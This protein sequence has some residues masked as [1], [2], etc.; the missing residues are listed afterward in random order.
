MSRCGG[1]VYCQFL[2]FQSMEKIKRWT[3]LSRLARRAT[4]RKVSPLQFTAFV[5]R[6]ETYGSGRYVQNSW[7]SCG[8]EKRCERV[9]IIWYAVGFR[10]E[11]RQVLRAA[12][13]R[14][15]RRRI[16]N[17][18][19]LCLEEA[20]NKKQQGYNNIGKEMCIKAKRWRTISLHQ[21]CGLPRYQGE[22]RSTRGIVRVGDKRDANHTDRLTE[23]WLFIKKGVQ[24][25]FSR[26]W[27][28]R[29]KVK[30][31]LWN[32]K[33]SLVGRSWG[34]KPLAVLALKM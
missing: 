21:D 3:F 12:I 24:L 2:Q 25:S 13:E 15:D 11:Y 27:L 28:V 23:L 22:L 20:R 31:W 14:H 8:A 29:S 33:A 9:V 10:P 5:L 19:M 16:V 7:L 18:K 6:W 1:N 30:V 4:K 26:R 34:Y 17:Y 32:Q